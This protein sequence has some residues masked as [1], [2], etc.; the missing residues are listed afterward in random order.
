[1]VQKR[2]SQKCYIYFDLI[3]TWLHILYRKLNFRSKLKQKKIIIII[4]YINLKQGILINQWM[5]DNKVLK[6][7]SLLPEIFLIIFINTKITTM[8]KA[9]PL[10]SILVSCMHIIVRSKQKALKNYSHTSN[11]HCLAMPLHYQLEI[12][13]LYLLL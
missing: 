7:M 11:F 13:K 2:F 4:H 9:G 5:G 1:M 6:T 10:M 12:Y 8:N 3:C